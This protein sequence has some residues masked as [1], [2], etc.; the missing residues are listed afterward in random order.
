MLLF[1]SNKTVVSAVDIS[2]LQ[3]QREPEAEGPATRARA[4]KETHFQV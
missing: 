2:H 4:H 3:I 1:K